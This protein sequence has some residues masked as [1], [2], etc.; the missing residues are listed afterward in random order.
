MRVRL[1]LLVSRFNDSYA[2]WMSGDPVLNIT[3]Y[4]TNADGEVITERANSDVLTTF[5]TEHWIEDGISSIYTAIH[6]PEGLSPGAYDLWVRIKRE[7][8]DGPVNRLTSLTVDN[9]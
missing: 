3:T 6:V 4:L 8:R 1:D 5:H 7:D 9:D 2:T